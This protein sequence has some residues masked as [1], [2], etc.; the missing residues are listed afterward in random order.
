MSR[1]GFFTSL[2]VVLLCLV[3]S[4][5]L[6][7]L[8]SLF[9][10]FVGTGEEQGG[11]VAMMT[12]LEDM[13]FLIDYFSGDEVVGADAMNYDLVFVHESLMSS[14]VG[15]KFK[16]EATPLI[17]TEF[18]ISDDMGLSGMT[19]DTDFGQLGDGAATS[20]FIQEPDHPL[21][22]GLEGEVQVYENP[23]NM[24][25]AI[26]GGG[27]VSVATTLDDDYQS[28]IYGFDA[29]VEDFNGEIVPGRR[30]FFFTFN[31]EE[32]NMTP[33]AW[34]LFD[35]AVYWALG[36][37]M[38]AS[39]AEKHAEPSTFHLSQNYPNPFNPTTHISYELDQH[40]HVQLTVHNLRGEQIAVLIN[41]QRPAGS[42]TVAFD[43]S[44]LSSGIYIYKLRTD[45]GFD[46]KKMIVTK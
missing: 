42:H 4:P 3:S 20:I 27:G 16:E 1:F 17:S 5:A 35:A 19:Q 29:G 26:V 41:G 32:E 37:E 15:D 9:C 46:A 23:G 12:Y 36:L 34:L 45:S 2:I 11:E 40:T 24:G 18:Y 43:A 10:L 8:D 38:P 28:V 31:G 6:A 39:V 30:V 25:F 7:Q 44:E 33:E 22:A 21:A 13:G 14:S